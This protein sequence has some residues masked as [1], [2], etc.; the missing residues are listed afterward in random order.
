MSLVTP[1]RIG[2]VLALVVLV[3]AAVV[4]GRAEG[5]AAVRTQQHRLLALRADVGARYLR[6]GYTAVD[7]V[8]SFTCLAYAAGGSPFGL[9][10]CFDPSGRLVEA[11]DRR[12]KPERIA[13]LRWDPAAA[14]LV[15]STTVLRAVLH[16]V[17]PASG[18]IP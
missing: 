4:Y 5:R 11:V 15:V 12:T 9:E 1:R 17:P 10:L 3:A 8:T 14:P 7:P 18:L 13:S 6:P 2:V 16:R